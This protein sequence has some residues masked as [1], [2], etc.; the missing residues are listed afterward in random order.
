MVTRKLSS[1]LSIVVALLVAPGLA[2]AQPKYNR[3]TRDIKVEATEAT[4]KM[5]A[6]KDKPEEKKPDDSFTADQFMQVEE[7]VQDINDQLIE[8]YKQQ[9]ESAE[10][11]DDRR[12][13]YAFRLA[14]AYS[15]KVRFN[16]FKAMEA[17]MKADK[18]TKKS[19]KDRLIR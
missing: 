6:K 5:E 19:D 14:E 1:A 4:K 11:D 8:I 15:Q 9:L 16:H 13:E 17:L 10:E 2:G 7:Q 18:T 12:P 3:K